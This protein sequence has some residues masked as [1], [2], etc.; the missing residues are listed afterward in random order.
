MLE[1]LSGLCD[2]GYSTAI[3]EDTLDR[4]RVYSILQIVSS[5]AVFGL[6]STGTNGDSG[7]ATS[8]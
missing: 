3:I 2:V 1:M 4:P 8:I 6:R 5:I 7:L